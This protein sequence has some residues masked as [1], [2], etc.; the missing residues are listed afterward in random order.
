[1]YL[2]VIEIYLCWQGGSWIIERSLSTELCVYVCMCLRND[3]CLSTPFSKTHLTRNI[4]KEQNESMRLSDCTLAFVSSNFL[5]QSIE[6][7]FH[8]D[9]GKWA[10]KMA[11]TLK[12]IEKQ[13]KYLLAQSSNVLNYVRVS[14]SLS[15][16]PPLSLSLSLF[17]S[18][19]D[20]KWKMS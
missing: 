3:F 9:V 18:V 1:M 11:L 10:V 2:R 14:N 15:L 12:Q 20:V 13:H 6:Q 16:F 5:T 17:L 8:Q 4:C 19:Y 7:K